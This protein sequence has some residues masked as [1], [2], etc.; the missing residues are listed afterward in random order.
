M[1]IV[2]DYCIWRTNLSKFCTNFNQTQHCA[3][4]RMNLHKLKF[5]EQLCAELWRLLHNFHCCVQLCAEN[6][7]P[8]HKT[9]PV[10]NFR[11][12]KIQLFTPN[13]TR[14]QIPVPKD[15]LF[16]T[17]LNTPQHPV[18]KASLFTPT[19]SQNL[20][21][22]II[23]LLSQNFDLQTFKTEYTKAFRQGICNK[24]IFKT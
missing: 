20:Q 8:Q 2:Q 7:H 18:L 16:A 12:Q 24:M 17:K 15:T 10:S 4:I 5:S 3:E 13:Y 11:S 19:S 9:L 22:Q 6:S 1:S 14:P 23:P 21:Y